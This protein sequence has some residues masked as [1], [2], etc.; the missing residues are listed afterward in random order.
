V[1][2]LVAVNGFK[3][4]KPGQRDSSSDDEEDDEVKPVRPPPPPP[5]QQISMQQVTLS[6]ENKKLV[7]SLIDQN[8]EVLQG[9]TL[10][11][12]GVA[13]S[14]P[15][16]T[17]SSSSSSSSIQSQTPQESVHAAGGG[18]GGGGGRNAGGRRPRDRHAQ[19]PVAAAVATGM[20]TAGAASMP[21]VDAVSA[22][23]RRDFDARVAS[24]AYQKFAT[25][26]QQLPAWAYC[27]VIVSALE[28]QQVVII[29]GETGCGK[30]TQVPQFLLDSGILAGKGSD[31]NIICTQPRRISAI[32]VSQRVA[33]E[34][35]E[36]IGR[37]VGYNI[38][39]EKRESRDTRLL[40]VTTG[41]L[42]RRL[43]GEGSKGPSSSASALASSGG[44]MSQ[45]GRSG[46]LDG[47]SHIIVDE[48]RTH[49]SF[50]D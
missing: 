23:L 29:S 13:T 45:F 3:V 49:A 2:M 19:P 27:D 46:G 1:G 43:E 7:S 14:T 16:A 5:M 4:K 9:L 30:S 40:F 20:A 50:A 10:S 39:L 25:I 34:R 31:V 15:V 41:V 33:Q 32:G 18:G 28:R 37:T 38:R 26:R 11:P 48:V 12:S 35:C 47:V 8:V 6:V 44:L 22:Q 24:V 36:D 42:L 17:S 21:V